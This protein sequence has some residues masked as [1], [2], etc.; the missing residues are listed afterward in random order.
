MREA[1]PLPITNADVQ[2]SPEEGRGVVSLRSEKPCSPRRMKEIGERMAGIK[3][4]VWRG[5]KKKSWGELTLFYDCPELLGKERL[6]MGTSGESFFQVNLHQNWNLRRVVAEWASL[7]G[8]EKV[9]DLFCGSGNLT[10]PLAQ[11]AREV[12]GIDHD[13][14]AIEHAAENARRNEL[15]NCRF[16]AAGAKEG[17]M[18]A[19]KEARR[20]DVV[21]LDPPR[22]GA[23][24]AVLDSLAS[25][26]PSKIL[27][28]SCEPPTLMRDLG[29][30]GELGYGLERF[31]ALDMFPQTYHIE[32]VAECRLREGASGRNRSDAGKNPR[33]AV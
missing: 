31:Q 30:L 16:I 5:K 12:W 23:A 9:L 11:R 26:R 32:V 13:P 1:D 14:Q 7:T 19:L 27:Y 6:R 22:A 4:I 28:V 18:M 2:I 25:I 15:G 3:G 21:V 24:R 29:R 10:L 8:R 33:A 17:I 20:A